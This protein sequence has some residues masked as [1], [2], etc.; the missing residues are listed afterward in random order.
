[1]NWYFEAKYW[2]GILSIASLWKNVGYYTLIFYAG[3]M[4]IDK[5]YYEA[6]AIDGATKFQQIRTISIPLMA[7]L[8]TLI[9]LLQVG[10]IFYSDFGLFYFVTADSGALYQTVDVIDTYVFRAL[11][12]TGDIGMATA[13]GLYQSVVGFVLVITVNYIVRKVNKENAIF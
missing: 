8:I 9:T 4:A 7:P 1:M 11:R 2:P 5:S 6:A 12:V 13:A 10:K 3:L